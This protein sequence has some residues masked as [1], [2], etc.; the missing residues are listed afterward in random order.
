ME[1]LVSISPCLFCRMRHKMHT[2]KNDTRLNIERNQT[3]MVRPVRQEI[4][5]AHVFVSPWLYDVLV[6]VTNVHNL[7]EKGE[8]GGRD[9][10]AQYHKNLN[11]EPHFKWVLLVCHC[12]SALTRYIEPVVID[13]CHQNDRND[14]QNSWCEP[15]VFGWRGECFCK[16][17]ESKE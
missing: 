2:T 10:L 6:F 9:H 13:F 15:I 4:A 11:P 5:L 8:E 16:A 17:E 3:Q 14:D 7:A 1:L 12:N